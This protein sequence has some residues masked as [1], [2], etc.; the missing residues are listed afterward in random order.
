MCSNG[1]FLLLL[2]L[3][4]F[5]LGL[6]LLLLFLLR[7]L[8]FGLRLFLSFSRALLFN[9]FS[10]FLAWFDFIKLFLVVSMGLDFRLSYESVSPNVSAKGCVRGIILACCIEDYLRSSSMSSLAYEIRKH[11]RIILKTIST[12]L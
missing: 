3:L 4:I 10:F 5:L 2:L 7:Y 8:Y 9:L 6:L 12:E 11:R 1:L